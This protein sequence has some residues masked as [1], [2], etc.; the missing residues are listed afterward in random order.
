MNMG[1]VTARILRPPIKFFNR[2]HFITEIYVGF[3]QAKQYCGR[4]IA[5]ADKK[6]GKNLFDLYRKGDYILIEGE[7]LIFQNK[8]KALS[9]AIY[10]SNIQPAHLIIEE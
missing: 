2:N 6:I 5:L 10:V 9:I 4:A 1:F 7:C 8:Q 3:P